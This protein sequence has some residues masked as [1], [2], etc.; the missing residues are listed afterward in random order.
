MERLTRL[1]DELLT[2]A[3]GLVAAFLPRPENERLGRAWEVDVGRFSMGLGL[4]EAVVGGLGF[5]FGGLAAMTG[6]IAVLNMIL[7]EGWFEGLSTAHFQGAGLVA[8]L[9]WCTHPLAWFLALV[10]VTGL[11]RVFTW[12]TTGEAIGEPLVWLALRLVQAVRR[13]STATARLRH[14]GP[15]RRDRL[16][17]GHDGELVIL[18]C[19]DRPEWSDNVTLELDGRFFR[20]VETSDRVEGAH[21]AVAHRFAELPEHSVVRRPLTYRDTLELAPAARQG[22]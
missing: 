6:D 3:G 15:L 22:S 20:L 5:M 13:S 18:T 7:L 11:A 8:L 16:V 14:L 21:L 1:V 19:R 12:T 9:I 2:F 10:G 4:V 17:W